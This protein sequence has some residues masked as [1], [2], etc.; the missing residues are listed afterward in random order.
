M[1]FIS[2]AALNRSLS[3]HADYEKDGGVED[4]RLVQVGETY[5]LTYTRYNK[6]D[7]QLCLTS[8]KT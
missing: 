1:A 3:P 5:Y 6:K 4:P 2:P 8:S 7:A